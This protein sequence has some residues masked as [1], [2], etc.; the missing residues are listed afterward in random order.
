MASKSQEL[1]H[2]TLSTMLADYGEGPASTLLNAAFHPNPIRRI[3][4]ELP[5][6]AAALRRSIELQVRPGARHH[7]CSLHVC[8]WRGPYDPC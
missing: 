5:P 3:D 7:V 1:P 6:S 4:L 2:E 8:G